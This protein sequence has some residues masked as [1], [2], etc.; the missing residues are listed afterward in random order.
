MLRGLTLPVVTALPERDG[1]GQADK[2]SRYDSGPWRPFYAVAASSREIL[3]SSR[4]NP[5]SQENGLLQ[6]NSVE[7]KRS[8]RKF[9]LWSS[10]NFLSE[11]LLGRGFARRGV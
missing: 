3:Y 2:V 7:Y 4:T 9:S 11:F 8:I 1:A 6:L 5:L 10:K